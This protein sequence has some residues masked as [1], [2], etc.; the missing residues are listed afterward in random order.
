MP[1][2]AQ[3]LSAQHNLGNLCLESASESHEQAKLTNFHY[4][5]LARQR[6]CAPLPDLT[7]S[8]WRQPHGMSVFETP[9]LVQWY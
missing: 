9:F 3:P 5:F 1:D 7:H 6:L 8:I 2:L 4:G